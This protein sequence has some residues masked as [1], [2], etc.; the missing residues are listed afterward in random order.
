MHAASVAEGL[1]Y[2]ERGEQRTESDYMRRVAVEGDEQG[3]QWNKKM[4]CRRG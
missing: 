4:A 3:K 2:I 1:R